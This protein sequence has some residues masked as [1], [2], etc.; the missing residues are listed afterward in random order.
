[1]TCKSCKKNKIKFLIEQ[2]KELK[3]L[4]NKTGLSMN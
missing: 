2:N 4:L 3:G 1:M